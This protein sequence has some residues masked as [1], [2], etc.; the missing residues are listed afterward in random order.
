MEVALSLPSDAER[1]WLPKSPSSEQVVPARRLW[2]HVTRAIRD[3]D[4]HRATQEKFLLEEAQ[5]QRARELQQSLTPWTP[6]LF[7]LDPTTQ[8]W[9]YRFEK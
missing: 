7:H 3:G 2:Q 1:A 4:Q 9:H 5:R 6:R 8:E